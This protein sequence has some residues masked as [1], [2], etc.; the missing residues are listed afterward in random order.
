LLPDFGEGGGTGSQA[1]IGAPDMHAGQCGVARQARAETVRIAR[2]DVDE[3]EPFRTLDLTVLGD[4]P[5]PRPPIRT[6]PRRPRVR[7]S[8]HRRGR[9]P[10]RPNPP[11]P[12]PHPPRTPAW[13]ARVSGLIAA[14]ISVDPH[15]LQTT[16]Q[17][18]IYDLL[19][20]A[21]ERFDPAGLGGDRS[22]QP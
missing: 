5:P 22:S 6:R 14:E 3:V 1:A 21:A 17:S 4:A 13:P 15:L 8:R 12:R 20:E 19:T 18:H 10:W 2:G 11:T 7:R 9:T 16:L